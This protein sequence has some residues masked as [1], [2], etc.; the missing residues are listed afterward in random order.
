MVD[1]KNNFKQGSTE[2]G[3]RLYD[4]IMKK[5]VYDCKNPVL[6][7]ALKDTGSLD[8]GFPAEAAEVL[9]KCVQYLMK[10]KHETKIS[11]KT[12]DDAIKMVYEFDKTDAVEAIHFARENVIR[13]LSATWSKGDQIAIGLGGMSKEDYEAFCRGLNQKYVSTGP[14]K[15]NDIER[16]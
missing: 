10:E 5:E 16:K 8:V 15:G 4:E 2:A 11:K 9:G 13:I 12:L 6:L 3:Q 7:K 14:V 1:S